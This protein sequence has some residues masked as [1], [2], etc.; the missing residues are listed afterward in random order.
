[1]IF[2]EPSILSISAAGLYCLVALACLAAGLGARAAPA[3]R[4][5]LRVWIALA[6]MFL[7]LATMRSLG[8][9]EWLRDELRTAL[10][11]QGSYQ[12]R[13]DV[14]RPIAAGF[15]VLVAVFALSWL[16]L[17]RPAA[18][19]RRNMPLLLAGAAAGGMLL[20]VG[21]RLISLHQIDVLLYGPL[22]LNWFADLG[23]SLVVLGAALV[24]ARQAWRARAAA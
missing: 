6:V 16:L 5:H 17:R 18:R 8:I 12:S 11:A 14:Q 4:Q 10:R 22:K 3:N 9:E 15:V 2:S 20:L 7:V 1:M 24:Y 13:R 21:L 19:A 23:A